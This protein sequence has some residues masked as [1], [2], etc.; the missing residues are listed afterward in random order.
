[1]TPSIART[2][3]E[4]NMKIV[5]IT[6]MH[7][8][9]DATKTLWDINTQQTFEKVLAHAIAKEKPDLLVLTGDLSEDASIGSYQYLAATIDKIGIPAYCIGGN[10]DNLALMQQILP[11]QYLSLQPSI[12]LN[13]WELI[14]LN[15]IVENQHYG[16]LSSDELNFLDKRLSECSAKHVLIALHH[17]PVLVD[18]PILDKYWLLNS[19]DFFA[20]LN[21][22]NNVKIAIYGHVH[23]DYVTY[24]NNVTFLAGPSSCMQF[25]PKA[26]E[27]TLDKLPPGYRWITLVADGSYSTGVHYL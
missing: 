12:N 16:I 27:F 23:Q 1:M 7:L 13:Q 6:D 14:L 2:T 21:K 3:S 5:Q 18:S 9:G 8:Y 20:V 25:L 22:Y 4:L 15:S 10:H 17:N 26:T 11:G 19:K 24:I